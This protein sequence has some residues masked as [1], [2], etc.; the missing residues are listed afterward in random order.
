LPLLCGSFTRVQASRRQRDTFHRYEIWAWLEASLAK[1]IFKWVT[2]TIVPV[3]DIHSL[4]NKVVS[5]ANKA[6][7]ISHALEFKK[8]FTLPVKSDIFHYHAELLQQIK[9]VRMQGESLGLKAEVPS[10][11]EQSLLL[12]AAW[13]NPVYRK[14]ALDY[15]MEDRV[16]SV[17]T[18]VR[19]LQKQQ[20]LT[21][22]LNL[23]GERGARHGGDGEVKVR[24]AAAAQPKYCFGFQKGKCTRVDCPFLHE[25]APSEAKVPDGSGKPKAK[26]STKKKSG[27]KD[28]ASTTKPKKSSIKGKCGKC[29]GSHAYSECQFSGVCEYCKR[30][31]HKT[32]QEKSF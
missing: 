18:L 29:G 2:R 19:E 21:A 17:E 8:I 25:K 9:L 14:I 5:L 27:K 16:V 26:S 11:M 28:K 30:Q 7:W 10:W 31:G 23:S 3:Y 32:V 12:I 15:T 20:L 6:T 1:G 22:H 13:Q 4:Y 24:A